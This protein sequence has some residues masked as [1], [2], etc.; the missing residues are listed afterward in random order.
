MTNTMTIAIV[1][2]K[3][4]MMVNLLLPITDLFFKL[5][6]L[7][8]QNLH[9]KQILSG[10]VLGCL[11]NQHQYEAREHCHQVKHQNQHQ[12]QYQYQ[13]GD[14]QERVEMLI[15]LQ[16]FNVL[17]GSPLHCT[18]FS[19]LFFRCFSQPSF[20]TSLLL[21]C[22]PHPHHGKP[23]CVQTFAAIKLSHQHRRSLL[24]RLS[25]LQHHVSS[26]DVIGASFWSVKSFLHLTHP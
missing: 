16:K 1:I 20:K 17:I 11:R 25:H 7:I 23:R 19:I 3:N 13:A 2:V 4:L 14:H 6:D 12:H 9:R 18:L 22:H 24:I 21:K 15:R 8:L 26:F 5:E 10:H